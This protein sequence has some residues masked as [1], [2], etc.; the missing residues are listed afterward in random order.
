MVY[1]FL[2][3]DFFSLYFLWFRLAL[4]K[5]LITF[6]FNFVIF[7]LTRSWGKNTK[8]LF[9]RNESSVNFLE[10]K[11][12][13]KDGRKA[14]QSKAYVPN[15]H[16]CQSGRKSFQ[17]KQNKMRKSK[18]KKVST[19]EIMNQRNYEPKKFQT[20]F[21]RPEVKLTISKIDQNQN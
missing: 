3:L 10:S 11:T 7:V 14:R 15:Y 13:A 9:P 5:I 12:D 19:K 8:T 1:T 17:D 2:G 20:K 21:D 4:V 18:T 16:F 6:T